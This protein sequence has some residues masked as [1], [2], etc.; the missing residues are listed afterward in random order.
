MWTSSRCGL[1]RPTQCAGPATCEDCGAYE[2]LQVH[3]K[4]YRGL[5][6]EERS[7][8]EVLCAQCHSRRHCR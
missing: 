7:D 3:H 8:L 6:Y 5:G 2:R 4:D 1:I